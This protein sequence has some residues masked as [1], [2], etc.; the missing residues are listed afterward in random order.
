MKI[1]ILGATGMLGNAV[2]KYFLNDTDHEIW[3]TA[4]KTSLN[5]L[6]YDKVISFDP[7]K[8]EYLSCL[9][10]PTA[11]WESVFDYDYVINCI[12][13]IKPFMASDPIAA[14]YI[15]SVFPWKMADYCND[16]QTKL[17]HITTDCVYSGK[18]G[19]YTETDMH[20]LLNPFD[21]YGCSKSLG[22]PI[23]RSMVIRTSIIG[24]EIH[25]N[26]SLIEWAKSQK[27]KE[28]NGFTN[29][30]W[31]GIT[32]K[33]Y[34]KVCADIITSNTW[35]KGLF[36]VYSP[37]DVSKYDMLNYFNERFDLNLKI[38]AVEAKESCDRTLRSNKDLVI[39]LNIPEIKE[40]I[41]EI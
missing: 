25:K 41:L 11:K 40:Q 18:K 10:R 19:K 31:N 3:L 6:N 20:D 8:D 23:N 14:R 4:R 37:S 34:A 30:L 16:F 36:H 22:E 2:S 33:Q 28:V 26:A 38:N 13:I 5:L 32:T 24:E 12:G 7:M 17:I 21:Q 15:N 27:G 35:E 39:K 1:L 29:H 9:D